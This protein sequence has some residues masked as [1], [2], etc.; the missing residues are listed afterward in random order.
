MQTFTIDDVDKLKM[1]ERDP[2]SLV[3]TNP[4]LTVSDY[5][6]RNGVTRQTVWN[7]V[8]KGAVEVKRKA[9]KNRRSGSRHHK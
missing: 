6:R 1:R 7:W 2:G 3:T 5:A 8:A 4:W 9:H